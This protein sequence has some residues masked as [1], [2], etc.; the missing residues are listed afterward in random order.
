MDMARNCVRMRT[1][2]AAPRDACADKTISTS[3]GAF[4][5]IS[6]PITETTAVELNRREVLAGAALLAAGCGGAKKTP[7]R[8]GWD[9]VRAQFALGPGRH[10]DAFLFAA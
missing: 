1:N 10:F 4:A 5:R 8:T 2:R 7:P 3:S 6:M 9:A